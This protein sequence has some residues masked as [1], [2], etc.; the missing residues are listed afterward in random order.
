MTVS[1]FCFSNSVVQWISSTMA[2]LRTMY[3][4]PYVMHF[5]S[6]NKKQFGFPA[7][8]IEVSQLKFLY[9]RVCGAGCIVAQ[10]PKLFCYSAASYADIGKSLFLNT[11]M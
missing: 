9:P 7:I 2:A 10:E 11:I 5:I 4:L 1:G 8:D 6:V 3:E